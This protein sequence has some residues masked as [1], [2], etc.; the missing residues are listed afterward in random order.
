MKRRCF[1]VVLAAMSLLVFVAAARAEDAPAH[2]AVKPVPRDGN[3]TK[4]HESI[5]A[6]VAKGNVDL[7]F[8]GDSITQGWEG[9]GRK[10]WEE[11]Y[12]KRNAAN[13]GIGG[14]RTQHV[15]WRLDNGNF[16]DISPK[17]AVVMIGTNNSG[18]NTPR[19]IADGVTAIVKSIQAKSPST[20]ILLLAI[21][22]RGASDKDARREV[23]SKTNKLVAK[24]D[25]GKNVHYL[26]IGASFLNDDGQLTRE[27]MPDLLHLSDKGYRLWAEAIEPRVKQLL[28]EN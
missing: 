7:V 22:P 28:G 27:I 1:H 18:S 3:W 17:L 4:R 15:L 26:D 23:N 20:K 11:Y 13:L 8:V 16:N 2:D 21:F 12:G 24:L 19:E 9:A 25:D 10:V 14:D 6:R 5:N